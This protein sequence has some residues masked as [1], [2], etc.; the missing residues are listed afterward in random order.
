MMGVGKSTVAAEV[1]NHLDCPA[2]DTDA[3]IVETAGCSVPEIFAREGEAGFRRRERE[4]IEALAG[5]R[6]VVALGGGAAA[7]P[8]MLDLLQR[9]G[10]L[11]YLTAAPSVL[12]A[13]IGA[14]GN[15]P[16]LAGLDR[17]G[18]ERRLAELLEARRPA[19]EQA[20][21][22]IA[23]D[24]RSVAEVAAAVAVALSCEARA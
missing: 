24:G 17:A 1:A 13:R 8:G 7:Q 20:D 18:R 2:F 3:R 19:Y 10:T 23:T 9:S 15:R 5:E 14:G 22:T 21:H 4:V 11:V 16:L 12:A 6:A